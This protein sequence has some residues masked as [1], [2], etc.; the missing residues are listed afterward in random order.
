MYARLKISRVENS[1]TTEALLSTRRG[2]D[3]NPSSLLRPMAFDNAS[4]SINVPQS[5]SQPIHSINGAAPGLLDSTQPTRLLRHPTHRL[6]FASFDPLIATTAASD[7]RRL[8]IHN[9]P[10][11]SDRVVIE[12]TPRGENFWRFVPSAQQENGCVGEGHWPRV[13]AIC[14]CV[15]NV[16]FSIEPEYCV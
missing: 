2:Q 15:I 10:D 16:P 9:Q 14:G 12:T 3:Q 7:Q 4:P 1:L 13:V 6:S 8:Y 11:G 5:G